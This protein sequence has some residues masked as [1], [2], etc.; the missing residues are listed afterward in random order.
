MLTTPRRSGSST[1]TSERLAQ[2]PRVGA[3]LYYDG[4]NLNASAASRDRRHLASTSCNINLHKTFSQPHGGGG[5]GGG[6]RGARSSSL[7]PARPSSRNGDR[8]NL[9]YD[10]AS[11]S[12]RC[13]ASPARSRLRSLLRYSVLRATNLREMSETAVSERQLPAT[14]S[15]AYD[16]PYDSLAM[17]EFVLSA[18]R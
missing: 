6:D 12:A 11:R 16:P 13:A 10:A 7:P 2:S 17:H 1:S 8:F 15:G 14:R 3:L 9:R 5:P 4:A 18:R